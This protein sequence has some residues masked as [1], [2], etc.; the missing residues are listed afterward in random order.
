[1]QSKLTKNK[2]MSEFDRHGLNIL[3]NGMKLWLEELFKSE[4]IS[5]L[6]KDANEKMV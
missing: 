3:R 1:M 4:F 6:I 2:K 5:K